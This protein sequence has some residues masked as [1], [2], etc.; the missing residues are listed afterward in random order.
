M[1]VTFIQLL[2]FQWP[3]PTQRQ[4]VWGIR[5]WNGKFYF[6]SQFL[7]S[8]VQRCKCHRDVGEND[9]KLHFLDKCLRSQGENLCTNDAL[10]NALTLHFSIQ[11]SYVF[12][13]ALIGMFLSS[14]EIL[15]LAFSFYLFFFL[16]GVRRNNLIWQ[17]CHCQWPWSSFKVTEIWNKVD[18]QHS[19]ARSKF[20]EG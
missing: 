6:C 17:S 19:E 18:C 7:S 20:T 8:R 5:N 9:G 13:R 1:V 11:L 3:W 2:H 4:G 15:V 16:K 12:N 14:V 10:C